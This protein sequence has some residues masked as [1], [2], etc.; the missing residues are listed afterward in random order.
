MSQPQQPQFDPT[1][2]ATYRQLR[3]LMINPNTPIEQRV[4][5][6]QSGF[7]MD[8][9]GAFVGDAGIIFDA[10]GQPSQGALVPPR[11]HYE[12][13]KQL[14]PVR[15]SA[16]QGPAAQQALET[17]QQAVTESRD[18]KNNT[19]R[20]QIVYPFQQHPD[21]ETIYLCF[22]AIV[23][24]AP[25]ALG[26]I[27]SHRWPS[28]LT[29]TTGFKLFPA[30]VA[31][32]L[33]NTTT[34]L[35]QMC[36]D[37]NH[38]SRETGLKKWQVFHMTVMIGSC[39]FYELPPDPTLNPTQGTRGVLFFSVPQ[40]PGRLLLK[41]FIN[42]PCSPALTRDGQ[43][44]GPTLKQLLKQSLGQRQGDDDVDEKPTL[45]KTEKRGISALVPLG[46]DRKMMRIVPVLVRRD[47][48]AYLLVDEATNKAAA[49]DPFDI[50]KVRT[51]AEKEG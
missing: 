11:V 46:D 25:G 30:N 7:R 16:P 26:G 23:A 32:W 5:L 20:G 29:N 18:T 13:M 50:P 41:A 21:R 22:P 38:S 39:I 17:I 45:I 9:Y 2:V 51:Q 24:G 8:G 47:N 14:Q 40:A 27:E 28:R 43:P 15:A 35:G 49:V 34:P 42:Q 3:M 44:T 33:Y 48:Y 12:R 1:L 31:T 36:I 19:W 6:V 4:R 37:Q 10:K